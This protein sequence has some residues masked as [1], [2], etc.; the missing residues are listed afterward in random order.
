MHK[1]IQLFMC[2][3]ILNYIC[4]IGRQIKHDLDSDPLLQHIFLLALVTCGFGIW[5][6]LPNFAGADEYSRLIQPMKVAGEFISDPSFESIHRGITDGRALGATFYLYALVLFPVFLYILLTGQIAEF[7]TLGTL[8]SRF[9]LW[10]AAPAWFWSASILLGRLVSVVLGVGSVYLTYR[11]GVQM[12]GRFVG[13]LAAVMLALSVGF[14][15][16]G[17][18][19]G[20]DM[21]MLFFLLLTLVL[22]D[23]YIE[24]GDTTIFLLGSVTGGTAIA[25]KLSGG[26]AAVVLG[27]A[28]VLRAV[29]STDTIRDTLKPQF[30]FAG[31]AIG[32]ASIWIGIPSILVGGLPELV[33][34]VAG[35][36]SSKTGR[37]GGF[38]A[39]IW[40]WFVYQYVSGLGIPLFIAGS[41]GASL[42]GV[43]LVTDRTTA[44]PLHWLLFLSIFIFLLVYS[45]WEFVRI[46]HLVPTYPAI[47]ILFAAEVNRWRETNNAWKSIRIGLAVVLVTT[48]A[49]AGAAEYQYITDP[50][51]EATEWVAENVE[52]GASMEVYDN[53]ISS[54]GTPHGR[55]TSHYQYDEENATD[56]PSLILNQ[57]AYTAWMTSMPERSPEY[58]QL[59][60]ALRYA[61]PD[62]SNIYPQRR[63]YIQGLLAGE[64]D[65]RVAATF[66]ETTQASASSPGNRIL[67]AGVSPRVEGVAEKVVIL[68]RTN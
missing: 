63:E 26:V 6:R 29:Y 24:T 18:L 65:Y 48:A 44:H 33:D 23:R 45:R 9:D 17:H 8:Q 39:S 54:L 16:Q 66:G 62:R 41:V 7:G 57:S 2:G 51:D 14:F 15:S 64:Y 10:H 13:R 42:T 47:L 25:F 19:V 67:D 56:V 38:S 30:V 58:I 27:A 5:F 1:L 34:R 46:R 35:S 11:L 68:E 61:N 37:T 52:Q 12:E 50:R 31:L 28:L 3:Y 55:E 43:R 53:S 4:S 32:I 59:S 20:E 36:V 22:A 60:G 21:P 40:Y 49:F